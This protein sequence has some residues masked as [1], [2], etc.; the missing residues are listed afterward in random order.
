MQVSVEQQRRRCSQST[1]SVARASRQQDRVDAVP[2][3]GRSSGSWRRRR[4]RTSTTK[5][6]VHQRPTT[7]AREGVPQQEVPVTDRALD[8]RASAASQRG[9]SQDL[10][11]EPQSQVEARQGRGG[12][13]RRWRH[14]PDGRR[15][16]ARRRPYRRWRCRDI[17]D[18][19]RRKNAATCGANTGAR[20]PHRDTRP[21]SAAG[22][23][24][25]STS[26]SASSSSAAAA[27][28]WYAHANHRPAS[29]V[30]RAS[31]PFQHTMIM[32]S[33]NIHYEQ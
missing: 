10:V 28:C 29:V 11:P 33:L 9:T 23:V 12:S 7:G 22:E 21:A 27:T 30:C 26:A 17:G 31:W 15:L 4:W 14:A 8:D 5:N 1:P 13:R 16:R 19:Q 18:W 32:N 2:A 6:G 20:Q 25:R 24:S 3:G